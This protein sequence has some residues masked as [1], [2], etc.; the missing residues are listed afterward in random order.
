[1]IK[2]GKKRLIYLGGISL[3]ILLLIIF[4]FAFSKPVVYDFTYANN[5]YALKNTDSPD[6]SDIVLTADDTAAD[7][8]ILPAEIGGYES[9]VVSLSILNNT[10]TYI[11][12]IPTT[13]EY[14]LKLTYCIISDAKSDHTLSL[15]INNTPAEEVSE[16][17]KNLPL[18]SFWQYS[19]MTFL[20]DDLGN[21]ILPHQQSVSGYITNFIRDYDYK[22]ER[23]LPVNLNKGQN[24]IT[25]SLSSGTVYLAQLTICAKQKLISYADYNSQNS[26]MQTTAG[27]IIIETEKPAYKNNLSIL[28]MTSRDMNTTPYETFGLPLNTITCAEAGNAVFYNFDVETTGFYKIGLKYN[29]ASK[30]NTTSFASITLDGETPFGELM[31]YPFEYVNDFAYHE[32]SSAGK[33]FEFYLKAGQHTIGLETDGVVMA[34]LTEPLSKMIKE[35]SQFYLNMKKIVGLNPDK[36]RDWVVTDYFP[37]IVEDFNTYMD[38]I[39]AQQELYA[40][41]NGSEVRSQALVYLDTTINSFKNLLKDPNKIPNKIAVLAEGSDSIVQSLSLA[42]N[43]IKTSALVTDQIII[44]GSAKD[45][46]FKKV[47]GFAKFWDGVKMFFGS[48]RAASAGTVNSETVEVWVNRPLSDVN[49]LQSTVDADFTKSTGIKVKLSV[50]KDEKKLILS[51]ASG[52]YPD[53]VMG[54]SSWIP[55]ELGLRGLV[56]DLNK[57]DDISSVMGRFNAGS[58]VPL[59]I[60]G[61]VLALPETQDAT[62]LYYRKD[63]LESLGLSVPSTWQDVIDMLPVLQRNG[64]NF[65]MPLS[66]AGANKAISMT[67]PFIYQAGGNLYKPDGSGTAI[68][69]EASIKGITLMTDLYKKYGVPKQVANFPESFRDGSIPIGIT[70]LSAY[71]QLLVSAPELRGLWDIAVSP[72]I[73]NAEG[74]VERWQSAGS[75][76]CAIMSRTKHEDEVWEFLKWWMSAEVQSNYSQQ[77]RAVWGSQFLWASANMTAFESSVFPEAHKQVIK[78]QWEWVLDVPRLPGWYMIERELS[79]AWNSVVFDNYNVRWCIDNAVTNSNREITR[80]LEE[81]GYVKNG[82]L[83]KPFKITTIEEVKNWGKD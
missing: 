54:V 43:E 23:A 56:Y 78:N 32:L 68:D 39:K 25:L 26:K 65:N 35:V 9:D 77:M 3:A 29:S 79:N 36:D 6:V 47:S 64:M 67:S 11:A 5:L 62:V 10:V 55:Y 49:L 63:I 48:F 66:G 30:P 38:I 7:T 61:K 60:D 28:P 13:G 74:E 14:N 40:K 72:G 1:M 21:D 18:L 73:E 22:Y 19:S 42:N 70:T 2:K 31:H 71:T 58:M 76:T 75:T 50:L 46:K 80:K 16:D 41:I 37:T 24:T 8:D 52:L 45:Y 4:T 20:R 81:F 44:Y 57:F 12:D 69:S 15:N 34:E 59:I 27:N 51:N 17:F 83:L 33:P 82:V 53:A